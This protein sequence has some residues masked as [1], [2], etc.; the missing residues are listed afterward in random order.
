VGISSHRRRAESAIFEARLGLA[1]LPADGCI[2]AGVIGHDRLIVSS[3][4]RAAAPLLG[5]RRLAMVKNCGGR[6]VRVLNDQGGT[7]RAHPDHRPRLGEIHPLIERV[8]DSP[9][10]RNCAGDGVRVLSENCFL[11]GPTR[12]KTQA[13]TLAISL[14]LVGLFG[15]CRTLRVNG[16]Q[17]SQTL[18]PHGFQ[19]ERPASNRIERSVQITFLTDIQG[20]RRMMV[21]GPAARERTRQWKDDRGRRETA[22]SNRRLQPILL[23]ALTRSGCEVALFNEPPSG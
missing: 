10:G 21:F 18:E 9:S 4:W 6:G 2:A 11:Q 5:G 20:R 15:S 16:L 22:G 8:P 12:P 7:R 1:Q 3:E 14:D 23:T 17:A 13:R 19:G